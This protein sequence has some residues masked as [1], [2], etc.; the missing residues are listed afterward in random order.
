MPPLNK[1]LKELFCSHNELTMLS[2]FGV[3]L[4]DMN[5]SHNKL[6][7]LP[8]LNTSLNKLNCSNNRLTYFPKINESLLILNC[9]FNQLTFL[10]ALFYLTELNCEHN[11]MHTL[12]NTLEY[13]KFINIHKTCIS[14][15]ILN[16]SYG[17]YPVCSALKNKI[18]IINRFRELYFLLKLKK[19]ILSWMWKSREKRIQTQFHPS[20]LYVFLEN[21]IQEDDNEAMDE[22]LNKWIYSEK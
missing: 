8:P 11:P 6:S 9:S 13:L 14:Q 12:P 1:T 22:F 4:K 3:S 16:H 21:G 10:P 7:S 5:C 17:M 18:Q 20:H 2:L 19:K 15:V